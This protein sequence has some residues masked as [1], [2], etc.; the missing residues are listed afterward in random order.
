ISMVK[1]STANDNIGNGGITALSS[2]NY[3][4]RSINWDNG[5][6][7]DA[8]AATWGNGTTGVSGVISIGNSLVGSTANDNVGSS[9]RVLTNGNYVV[10]SSAW[11]NGGITNAGA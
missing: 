1:G 9:I 5:A 4:I 11:D 3:V 8:G 2:S 6:V 7:I 10:S